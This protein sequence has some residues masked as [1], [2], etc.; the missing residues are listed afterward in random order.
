MQF[1]G[2][3]LKL[4]GGGGGGGG[5]C[6]EPPLLPPHADTRYP[7][8]MKN[9]AA[10]IRNITWFTLLP[11]FNIDRLCRMRFNFALFKR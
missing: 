9:T 4:A 3:V 2:P 6:A 7:V 10:K 11:Q 5:V 1:A 8:A